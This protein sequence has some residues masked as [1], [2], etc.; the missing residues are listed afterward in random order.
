MFNIDAGNVLKSGF[1][2][3]DSLFTSDEEKAEAK[4]KLIQLQQEGKLKELEAKQKV[5]LAEAQSKDKWT[6]RAR[7]SF[8][9]VFYIIIF[10][11]LYHFYNLCARIAVCPSI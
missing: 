1:D 11:L 6:S 5:M 3:I 7:P 4:R 2:L 9:Y 8:M 10:L